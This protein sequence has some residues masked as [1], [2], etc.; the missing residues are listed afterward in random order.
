MKPEVLPD[1]PEGWIEYLRGDHPELPAPRFASLP[2]SLR[3]SGGGRSSGSGRWGDGVLEALLD[4]GALR[5]SGAQRLGRGGAVAVLAPVFPD[6][7]GGSLSQLL[8]CL[9]AAKI[10]REL[11][12]HAIDSVAV[13]W[14]RPFSGGEQ[15]PRPS[16]NLLDPERKLHKF[17]ERTTE[18]AA[19]TAEGVHSYEGTADLVDRIEEL[20]AGSFDGE[21]LAL[22]KT[23][24]R[25]GDSE[26]AR[27]FEIFM[28]PFQGIVIDACSRGFEAAL[29]KS[30]NPALCAP[31]ESSPPVPAAERDYYLQ[32]LLFER[33]LFV[34]DPWDCA[35]FVRALPFVN[36]HC[37]FLPLSWPA[38]GATIVDKDSRRTFRKYGLGLEDLFAGTP[39]LPE[40]F[41][42]RLSASRAGPELDSL[43]SQIGKILDALKDQAAENRSFRKAVEKSGTRISF[44]LRKT[45]NRF[46]SARLQK[47]DTMRRRFSR[48]CASLAPDGKAQERGL[49]AIHFLLS[50]GMTLPAVLY[51]NLDIE[52]FDHQI[53]D[54]Y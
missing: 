43:E 52:S 25:P 20:G 41:G 28:Q 30:G 11:T 39:G 26:A 1:I 44:Q 23:P 34:L 50:Y 8:K 51:E 4:S 32:C 7:F 53:V 3:G 19:L 42:E 47:L 15:S 49:S 21:T 22:L 14:I 46:E 54:V 37:G 6:P 38:A 35:S 27:M 48:L 36:R 33:P 12:G 16:L 17:V 5:G 10:S 13:C 9:T 29:E 2:D 31:E 18:P 40:R 24:G 45:G